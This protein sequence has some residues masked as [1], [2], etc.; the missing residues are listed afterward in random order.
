[1]K[2]NQRLLLKY[3]GSRSSNVKTNVRSAERIVIV[4]FNIALDS[5]IIRNFGN[6]S[7]QANQLHW[8]GQPKKE[9][10]QKNITHYLQ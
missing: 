10:M 3:F 4:E 8:Y 7:F 5:T 2:I 6:E 9:K 1:M